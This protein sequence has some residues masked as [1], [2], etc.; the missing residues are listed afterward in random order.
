MIAPRRWVRS[1]LGVSGFALV[2]GSTVVAATDCQSYGCDAGFDSNPIVMF[3]EGS[4]YDKDGA[5]LSAPETPF[6]YETS[7]PDG[8]HLNF[9]GGARYCIYHKLGGRPFSVNLWVSFSR[10]GTSGGNEAP[11]AGNM[12]EVLKV[13]DQVIVVR[14][15]SCG[16]YFLRVTASAPLQNSAAEPVATSSDSGEEDPCVVK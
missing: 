14:N 6:Y 3:N 15:D 9:Q 11:P 8:E 1:A 16:A 12:A 4:L 13:T 2:A 10:T 5:P 7:A